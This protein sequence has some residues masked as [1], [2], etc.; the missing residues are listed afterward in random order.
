MV[1][2]E[3]SLVIAR[4]IEKAFVFLV[5]LGNDSLWQE[6]VIESRQ[7]SEGPVD[8]GTRGRDIRKFLGRQIVCDYE[9]VE[10]EPKEKSDSSLSLGRYSLM[11][12]TPFS[13]SSKAQDSPSQ[14]RGVLAMVQRG[15]TSGL[16]SSEKAS[17]SRL[18]SFEEP[19]RIPIR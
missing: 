8:M 14:L 15:R 16:S 1:K 7:I 12:V 13:L 10:Y 18:K 19:V 5:N 9:I 6:G 4:P 2:I 17:R 11:E 3:H